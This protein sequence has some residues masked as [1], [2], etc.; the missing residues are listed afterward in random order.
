MHCCRR[1]ISHGPSGSATF[2]WL[3]STAPSVRVHL[4]RVYVLLNQPAPALELLAPLTK[5]PSWISPDELR[6]DPTWAA[7]RTHP[8]F[9]RLV[10]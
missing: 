9:S 10:R 4:A 1:M 3:L 6:S 8:L 2:A 5:V 7:L